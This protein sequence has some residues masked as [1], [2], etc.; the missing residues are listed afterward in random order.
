MSD[1]SDGWGCLGGLIVLGLIGYGAY[2][3]ADQQGYA[4]HSVETT[5]TA[6]QNWLVGEVKDCYSN[7]LDSKTA[8]QLGKEDGYVATFINCD[9][10][11]AH[12]I[13][14][15]LYGQLNQPE[16]NLIRWRCTRETDDFTC[17]QTGTD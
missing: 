11:P 17:R 4:Q 1:E 2:Y 14:V 10:G 3:A 12:T 9:N 8:T 13:K 16:H 15:T 6:Q 5:I 7:V